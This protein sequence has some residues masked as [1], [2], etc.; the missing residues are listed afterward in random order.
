M[1][2]GRGSGAGRSAGGQEFPHAWSDA[3]GFLGEGM[4]LV[5][6][7]RHGG[8]SSPPYDTLNLAFHTGDDG[9]VIVRNRMVVSH[10]LG[11]APR[12]FVYLEQ[13]HDTRV[14]RITARPVPCEGGASP[15]VVEG[16][17]GACTAVRGLALAVLT[18]DCVPIALADESIPAVAVV[19]AGW[20]GTIGDIAAAALRAMGADPRR[21]KAVLGPSIAPC[22]YEVDEGRA[23]L[24]VERYGEKS[25][26]VTGK[27]G[28]N[29]D[30]VRANA[31]N[32]M[33]AG[34]REE[35]LLAVGGCTCCDGRY[36][37]FR[38][39]G[40]TGRQGAFVFLR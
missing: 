36:F 8:F 3:G 10:A 20:K 15:P 37:S 39:D 14:A 9:A 17:D 21:V 30:L 25:E 11:I 26:V 6:T 32:L 2:K 1:T 16:A 13:V 5:F 38:R 27:A 28:R 35:N 19:H 18:A 34:V 40:V 31:L 7:D 12:D 4:G 23:G 33:E 29:L 22:C 24:F